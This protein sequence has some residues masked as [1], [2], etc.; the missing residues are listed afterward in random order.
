MVH[1]GVESDT[2]SGSLLSVD[3]SLDVL[4]HNWLLGK[5]DESQNLA[6][7]KSLLKKNANV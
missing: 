5:D 2:E 3:S 7:G 6:R 4:G 1:F